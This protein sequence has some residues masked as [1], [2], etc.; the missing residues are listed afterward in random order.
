[1]KIPLSIYR[2]KDCTDLADVEITLDALKQWCINIHKKSPDEV[3]IVAK[4]WNALI[5]LR[6]KYKALK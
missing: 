5:K 4:R 6:S 3:P 1:M 2:T